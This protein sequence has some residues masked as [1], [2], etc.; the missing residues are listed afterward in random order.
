MASLFNDAIPARQV[1]NNLELTSTIF[2]WMKRTT[3]A[4][5]H[6]IDE[7]RDIAFIPWGWKINY[8]MDDFAKAT[9]SQRAPSGQRRAGSTFMASE[10]PASENSCAALGALPALLFK[11]QA[12]RLDSAIPGIKPAWLAYLLDSDDRPDVLFPSLR[13]LSLGSGDGL[14]CFIVSNSA[15]SLK[16]LQIDFLA[17]KAVPPVQTACQAIVTVLSSKKDVALTHLHMAQ[18]ITPITIQHISQI[19][20]LTTLRIAIANKPDFER[21]KLGKLSSLSSLKSLH[22]EQLLDDEDESAAAMPP[23]ADFDVNAQEPKLKTIDSLHVVGN[24]ATHLYTLK[25]LLPG[26]LKT[27]KLEVLPGADNVQTLLLPLVFSVYA[28]LN[29]GLSNVALVGNQ[30][31]PYEPFDHMIS[32]R[33]LASSRSNS[34]L[35]TLEPFLSGL[36]QLQHLT[37][38]E[39]R[40]LPFLAV[41]LVPRV[42]EIVSR[43]RALRKL[44]LLPVVATDLQEYKLVTPPLE[45]LEV[46]S[47]RCPHLEHLE[48]II[49]LPL[50]MP[51]PR[52]RAG[53]PHGLTLLMLHDADFNYENISPYDKFNL[54]R[55]IEKC[56]PCAT[57][58]TDEGYRRRR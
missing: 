10:L 6:S 53:P 38:L 45:T 46:L 14:S 55:Y 28:K 39:I 23:D 35:N 41:D 36:S 9:P 43:L 19:K 27:L 44:V 11:S 18:A 4:E 48:T 25:Q 49:N 20:S 34:L 37:S 56:F 24:G 3:G 42:L 57:L 26:G 30:N 32:E 52:A 58:L 54:A 5:C 13:R 22:I 29:P 40:T 33:A 51:E 2:Q 47:T 21:L 1:L 7:E 15:R 8:A 16:S 31:L 50:N 17:T 12:L